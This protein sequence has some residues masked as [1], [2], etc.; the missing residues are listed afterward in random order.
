MS[1][2]DSA[3]IAAQLADLEAKMAH[4]AVTWGARAADNLDLVGISAA[5]GALL[6]LLL[7][8]AFDRD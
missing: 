3:R 5:G 6:A 2:S 7:C 1:P 4:H 8:W